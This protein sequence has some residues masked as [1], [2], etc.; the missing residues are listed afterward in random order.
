[1][2]SSDVRTFRNK[3]ELWNRF[4]AGSIL[5]FSWDFNY[6]TNFFF[7]RTAFTSPTLRE[8]GYCCIFITH[9]EKHTLGRTPPDEWSARRRGLYLTN[10][11]QPQE[12]RI[13]NTSKREADYDRGS[14]EIGLS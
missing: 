10:K 14:T 1:M 12:I 11:K 6:L 2:I 5:H 3:L 13:L 8:Q 7:G 9:N 4:Y